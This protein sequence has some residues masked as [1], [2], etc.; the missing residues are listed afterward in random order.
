MNQQDKISIEQIIKKEYASTTGIRIMQ[1][2]KLQYEN[3]FNGIKQNDAVHIFSATKAIVSILIGIAIDK[4]YIQSVHQKILEFFP[5]YTVKKREKTLQQVT[6]EDMLTMRVPYKYHF[7]PYTKYFTCEDWVRFSLD[8]MGG[9]KSI[10]PFF[11]AALIGPDVLTAILARA[12][13]QTT[14][15]FANKHLFQPLGIHVPNIVTFKNKKEQL[16]YYKKVV[17][18][19][20]V[21]DSKGNQCAGWGL[22]LS[23]QDMTKIAQLYLNE[24][25]WE[26][27]QVVSK[28]WIKQSTIEHNRWMKLNIGFGYLWWI[29]KQGYVAMGDGGNII[30]VNPKKQLT[31][32]M[33]GTFQSKSKD[34]LDFIERFIEPLFLM[35]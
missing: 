20:W 12:S 27:K 9:K 33:G 23:I 32:V 24:G 15:Q 31:V 21:S 18:S 8:V 16:S 14:L 29:T 25:V 5:D 35:Q 19:G 4:G 6:I 3:Y 34:R 13:G 17:T 26:G 11:Y 10:G 30:Y 2:H 7:A 22:S 28:N 1:H